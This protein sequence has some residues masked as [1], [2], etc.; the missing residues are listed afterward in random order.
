MTA[1]LIIEGQPQWVAMPLEL[2]TDDRVSPQAKVLFGILLWHG[3]TPE[4]CF[5]GHARL[6]ELV[7]I[8]ERSVARPLRQL[9][10]IGWIGRHRR[11]DRNGQ[12]TSDG[13]TLR[14][15]L[16]HADAPNVTTTRSCASQPRDSARPNRAKSRGEHHQEEREE[17]EQPTR[18]VEGEVSEDTSPQ[19]AL[20]AESGDRTIEDE[21]D[22]WWTF[23]AD[24]K[25]KIGKPDARKA[26]RDAV[27]RLGG[28]RKAEDVIV[29]GTNRWNRQWA[30]EKREPRHI[31][32]PATW[33]RREDYESV[34][35]PI[36][37]RRTR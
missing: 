2:L 21:F 12:R 8:A 25:R 17:E 24:G 19:L 5:P 35:E 23:Y 13:Y 22:E 9:E 3:Q 15:T 18:A 36:K 1:E 4:R 32:H 33:L 26:F 29:E 14:L 30:A 10:E 28:W 6:A 7:G 20:V 27:K 37:A 11:I 31:P 34:P 16:V